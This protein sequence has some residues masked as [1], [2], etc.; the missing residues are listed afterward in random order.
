[1]SAT[2]VE[3][4]YQIR[5][6]VLDGRAKLICEDDTA[7]YLTVRSEDDSTMLDTRYKIQ[8][9]LFKVGIQL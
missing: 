1:M 2:A 8:E 5:G 7:V 3:N 6:S 9:T 4:L